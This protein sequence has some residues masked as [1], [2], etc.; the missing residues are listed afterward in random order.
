MKSLDRICF[1]AECCQAIWKGIVLAFPINCWHPLPGR[2][3]G[4][5]NSARKGLLALFNWVRTIA[6]CRGEAFCAK[7]LK[8][9]LAKVR[10]SA[11]G[12]QGFEKVTFL[13]KYFRGSL[14][15]ASW[16][17]LSKTKLLFQI[18]RIGRALPAGNARLAE[19]TMQKHKKNLCSVFHCSSSDLFSVRAFVTK[20]VARLAGRGTPLD[21]SLSLST[22]ACIENTRS[23]GGNFGY[24]Q[25]AC[26]SYRGEMVGAEELSRPPPQGTLRTPYERVTERSREAFSVRSEGAKVRRDEC[27]WLWL[28]RYAEE[29][30]IALEDWEF[31]R[32]YLFLMDLIL[33]TKFPEN[34]LVE[35]IPIFER[36]FKVRIVTKGPAVLIAYLHLW[37]SLLLGLLKRDPPSADSL[38]SSDQ[39]KA[40]VERFNRSVGTLQ[41][42]W[43]FRSADLTTATDLMPRDLCQ[44][45][46]EGIVEGFRRAHYNIDDEF[47]EILHIATSNLDCKWGN[48]QEHTSRGILMGFPTSWC[49]L[50]FYNMWLHDRAW[51]EEYEVVPW[52]LYDLFS[53]IG[54]DYVSYVPKRVSSRYTHVLERTGGAISALKDVESP[55]AFVLGEEAASLSGS[56]LV[57][58]STVSVR[59]MT[60]DLEWTRDLKH[61]LYDIP[62]SLDQ[63]CRSL[64]LRERKQFC[65]RVKESFAPLIRRFRDSGIPPFLPREV[66]GAGFPA[67]DRN[68]EYRKYPRFARAIRWCISSVVQGRISEGTRLVALSHVWSGFKVKLESSQWAQDK[69]RDLVAEYGYT[70]SDATPDSVSWS[71]ASRR[72]LAFYSNAEQMAVGVVPAAS[73]VPT[74]KQIGERL[75]E[76][77]DSINRLLPPDRLSD[78][79]ED[80]DSG[81]T[82]W[83][84][85]FEKSYR[86]SHLSGVARFGRI[87]SL[88]KLRTEDVDSPWREPALKRRKLETASQDA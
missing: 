25:Q 2:P 47:A 66:G 70:S 85:F 5:W 36:G 15:A 50:S 13:E 61:P 37:N 69:L 74:F 44:A 12:V 82:R 45:I 4:R 43:V 71:D 83:S 72:L 77:V 87:F 78:P 17:G 7:S 18:S 81:V 55:S 86:L 58:I 60:G 11:L 80:L 14:D 8:D 3:F 16:I 33:S 31:V 49:I 52:K 34:A 41:D 54:D 32:E 42:G 20:K 30:G 88:E 24:L 76:A 67:F 21:A 46:V 59:L 56:Q 64:P 79:V 23:K 27:L 53:I 75:G 68:A 51:R 26:D 29:L 1:A 19:E 48:D 39:R 6:V 63:A 9:Q 22:S 35:A 62:V 28:P 57:C 38:S 40:Y 84:D 10:A 65:A 73:R